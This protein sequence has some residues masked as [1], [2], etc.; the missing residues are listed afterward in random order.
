MTASPNGSICRKKVQSP[1]IKL[2]QPLNWLRQLL[3]LIRIFHLK[4]PKLLKKKLKF[5]F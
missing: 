5:L 4:H 3:F 2:F 1:Q